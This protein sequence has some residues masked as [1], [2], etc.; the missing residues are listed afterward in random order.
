MR[1][2]PFNVHYYGLLCRISAGL[3]CSQTVRNQLSPCKPL[4]EATIHHS[5]D[6][7]FAIR[8]GKW[9]YINGQGPGSNQWDGPSADGPEG[10]LYNLEADLHEDHNLYSEYPEVVERLKNLLELYKQQGYSR[11]M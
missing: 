11:A 9:K 6:G 7:T 1:Y 10:Q 5:V 8:Q 3:A 4:R 2:P